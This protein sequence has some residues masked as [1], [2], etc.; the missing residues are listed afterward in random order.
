MY[1][2]SFLHEISYYNES[3]DTNYAFSQRKL[4]GVLKMSLQ[5][6]IKDVMNRLNAH[7]HQ[8]LIENLGMTAKHHVIR[9]KNQQENDALILEQNKEKIDKYTKGI[10]N[11]ED[12]E[13]KIKD[14]IIFCINNYKDL[15]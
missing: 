14:Q 2:Y 5:D 7:E 4:N 13:E 15:P 11:Y 9:N 1:V 6:N 3:F 12:F 10:F 8:L